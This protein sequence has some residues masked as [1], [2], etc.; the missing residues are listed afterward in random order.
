M[1]PTE[2]TGVMPS[3]SEKAPVLDG[4]SGTAED[5]TTQ[6]MKP[7]ESTGVTPSSHENVSSL[8]GTPHTAEDATKGEA[9][10]HTAS[11]W[12]VFVALCLA[13]FTFI[14]I[15]FSYIILYTLY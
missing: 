15:N 8:D 11:F 10:Q 9:M 4:T 2:G 1:K 13:S 14:T 7:A 5:S 3:F 12:M 6:T